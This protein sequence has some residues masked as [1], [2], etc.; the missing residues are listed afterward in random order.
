MVPRASRDNAGKGC[1]DNSPFRRAGDPGGR[2][3]KGAGVVGAASG[4]V[5]GGFFGAQA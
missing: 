4:A 2:A 3:I 1:W 5:V